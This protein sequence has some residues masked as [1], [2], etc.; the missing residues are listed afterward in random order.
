LSRGGARAVPALDDRD[1]LWRLLA[2]LTI[3]KAIDVQ[4]RQRQQEGPGKSIS[5][6]S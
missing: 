5:N 6:S 1:D 4:R 2:V 3:R